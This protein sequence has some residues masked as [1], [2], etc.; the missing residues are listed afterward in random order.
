[1][2]EGDKEVGVIL[3]THVKGYFLSSYFQLL[4]GDGRRHCLQIVLNKAAAFCLF[5]SIL[6][7][8]SVNL[9]TGTS[10]Q[11]VRA[12]VKQEMGMVGGGLTTLPGPE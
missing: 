2:G 7:F 9:L 5:L 12:L 1:M 11:D 4:L 10:R 3:P 8:P 6:M